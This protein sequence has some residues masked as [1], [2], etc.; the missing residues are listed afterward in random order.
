MRTIKKG[1]R[2][3]VSLAFILAIAGLIGFSNYQAFAQKSVSIS[4][5][6]N[7]PAEK[8]FLT[9]SNRGMGMSVGGIKWR[10]ADG[11]ACFT[12]RFFRIDTH[13]ALL[14]LDMS[15]EYLVKASSDGIH[16]KTILSSHLT[17]NI[18]HYNRGYYQANLLPF[19]RHSSVVYV[20]FLDNDPSGGWG[21]SLYH[22]TL[23][24]VPGMHPL[25]LPNREPGTLRVFA[26]GWGQSLG[27]SLSHL[28]FNSNWLV[29][30]R[31]IR[32]GTPLKQGEMQYKITHP[33]SFDL[34]TLLHDTDAVWLDAGSSPD[35]LKRGAEAIAQFV[36]LGGALVVCGS[37]ETYGG[38]AGGGFANTPIASILPVKILSSPDTDDNPCKLQIVK[39]APF[40][41][42]VDWN[43]CPEF[44]GHNRVGLRK[45]AH[46]IAL[47]NDG[48]PAMAWWN[49]GKGRVFCF[50]STPDGGWGANIRRNWSLPYSRFVRQLLQWMMKGLPFQSSKTR[51]M[52]IKT[53]VNLKEIWQTLFGIWRSMPAK[54][55]IPLEDDRLRLAFDLTGASRLIR[56]GWYYAWT[57]KAVDGRL[58]N[59][60]KS[61][62]Y[63][64]G[65]NDIPPA[66]ATPTPFT[67]QLGY[68]L[69]MAAISAVKLAKLSHSNHALKQARKIRSQLAMYLNQ[70]S[71]KPVPMPTN[72]SGKQTDQFVP[73]DSLF[74]QEPDWVMQCGDLD[75]GRSP[76]YLRW[77]ISRQTQ[78][79]LQTAQRVPVTTNYIDGMTTSWDESGNTPEILGSPQSSFGLTESFFTTAST[80]F[81]EPLPYMTYFQEFRKGQ[82]VISRHFSFVWGSPALAEIVRIE[83]DG[84]TTLPPSRLVTNLI[85][86]SGRYLSLLDINGNE[87]I[88]AI[89]GMVLSQEIAPIAPG[90]SEWRTVL[91]VL[92]SDKPSL[93]HNVDVSLDWCRTHLPIPGLPAVTWKLSAPVDDIPSPSNMSTGMWTHAINGFFHYLEGALLTP[94]GTYREVFN[95]R[96]LWTDCDLANAS[97][98]L[99]LYALTTGNKA[100]RKRTR[101]LLEYMLSCQAPSGAFYSRRVLD[102]DGHARAYSLSNWCCSVA[103]CTYPLTLGYRLFATSDPIFARRCLNAAQRAGG[104]LIHDT[105]ADGSLFADDSGP[106]H[107]FGNK[108]DYPGDVHGLAV[109]DLCELYRL[110]KDQRYLEGAIHIG[111]YL[112]ANADEL[113]TNGNAIGGLC[114]LW[115]ET[116][117]MEY[118]EKAE[119]VANNQ[120][121]GSALNGNFSLVVAPQLDEL[122][123]AYR[124]WM[125]CDLARAEKGMA[126]QL[127]KSDNH[128]AEL[129]LRR[130]W[131]HLGTADWMAETFFGVNN[132]HRNL[133]DTTGGSAW[134]N[135]EVTGMEISA[136]AQIDSSYHQNPADSP[137]W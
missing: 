108:N 26:S 104:W 129:F 94:K 96:S 59:G 130:S 35:T 46:L 86:V 113:M 127:E 128:Q 66:N 101:T 30:G 123:Y 98:G 37:W 18:D 134:G 124:A 73:G 131:A 76:Q 84:K 121:I 2:H 9:G 44:H 133:Q 40:F 51:R 12:Y 65:Y 78:E 29:T 85:P 102:A 80:W 1:A 39:D 117:D 92:G 17:G 5:T 77:D 69:E 63:L 58:W 11:K 89:N 115:Y 103:Q 16:W 111:R 135:V 28:S 119:E 47:W 13:Y 72:W 60:V 56:S 82:I 48:D 8:P 6:P 110:T 24:F 100:A 3:T 75:H 41:K 87:A 53:P 79:I 109:M 125:L 27:Q 88:T 57:R 68:R 32:N 107:D 52:T 120:L 45:G 132:Q 106:R 81:D 25:P 33:I 99:A 21:P 71:W 31:F 91:V 93:K 122:D 23:D 15:G 49:Y 114:A 14:T 126:S 137:I 50:T 67:P 7:T 61:W 54:G 55:D 34:K 64:P 112:K 20:R 42:G 22:L 95:Q 90:K 97:R 36:K 38:N 4:F 70:S 62:D 10:F 19:F 116:H 136:L 83:N 118:L 105:D 74:E 43:G